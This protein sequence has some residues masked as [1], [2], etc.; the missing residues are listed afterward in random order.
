MSGFPTPVITGT[1]TFIALGLAG[2]IIGALLRRYKKF[3]KDESQ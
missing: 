3:N 2:G 1:I